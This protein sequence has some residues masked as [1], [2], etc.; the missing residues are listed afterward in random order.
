MMIRGVRGAITV[1]AD[2]TGD[3]LE[4]TTEMLRALIDAN[5]I[6]EEDV[7]SVSFT[8]TPDLTACY[9]AKAARDMGW[10]Q[11]ALMA[12]AEMDV[13]G[14]LAK[15]VRVLIHWNTSKRQDE[16]VHVFM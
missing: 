14:G 2:T 9:P 6:D 15:C 13:P 16:L 11:V 10:T 5:S 4:G 12:F 1:D 3:I 7:A 8:T